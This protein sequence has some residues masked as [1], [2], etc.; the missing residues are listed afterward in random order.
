MSGQNNVLFIAI[1]TSL[2]SIVLVFMICHYRQTTYGQ[3][4][5]VRSGFFKADGVDSEVGLS[6]FEDQN[7]IQRDY[8]DLLF[9]ILLRFKPWYLL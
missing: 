3:R 1:V 6:D 8:N 7:L 2:L 4:L 9:R 5:S